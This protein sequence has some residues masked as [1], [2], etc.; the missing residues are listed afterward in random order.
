M[1]NKFFFDF[2]FG[3]FLNK[4]FCFFYCCVKFCCF[5]FCVFFNFCE[6]IFDLF[7]IFIYDDNLKVMFKKFEF[8]EINNKDCRV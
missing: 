4:F 7:L 1:N 2:L 6:N 3:E 8:S 5:L